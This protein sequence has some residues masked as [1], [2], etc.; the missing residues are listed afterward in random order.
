[1]GLRLTM[2]GREHDDNGRYTEG[3]NA[4][5]NQA[6]EEMRRRSR[7]ESMDDVQG[8]QIGFTPYETED[9]RR[10]RPRGEHSD[11]AEMLDMMHELKKGQESLKAGLAS[12]VKKL[13]PRMDSLLETAV[14]VVDNPPSTWEPHMKRQDYLGIAKME[15]KELLTALEAHK[16]AQDIRKELSHTIAALLQLAVY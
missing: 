3:Y 13:D 8:R 1:M 4:G 10:G 5:F 11:M 9:R 6:M 14:G 15:G 12:P 16:S 2:G 7:G